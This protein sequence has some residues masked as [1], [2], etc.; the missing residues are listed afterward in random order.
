MK[1]H[2][3]EI[4]N[5]NSLKG[6]WKINLDD[7]FFARNHN[8]FVIH[9][10]TGSGKT[11]ILDAITLALYGCT[12]RLKS[13]SKTTNEA[14]SLNTGNCLAR[15]TYTSRGKRYVSQFSQ[16]RAHNN[17]GGNLLN[18][19]CYI[20]DLSTNTPTEKLSPTALKEKTE[21]LIGLSYD[22][23]CRSIL[24]AQ[25][26][27]DS[28]INASSGERAQILAKLTG[29][30]RF[31]EI[32][33]RI[34]EKRRETEKEFETAR[35][36][37][38]AFSGTI[39]DQE[40]IEELNK[41]TN[42]LQ[43]K[44]E[45]LSKS[46]QAVDKELSWFKEF[47]KAQ[48]DAS[49]A[50]AK[51][52]VVIAELEKSRQ[53]FLR[54][55]NAERAEK[56]SLSYQNLSH[57]RRELETTGTLLRQ[58]T[59]KVCQL[60]EQ[61]EQTKQA[62]RNAE[63][64]HT[65]LALRFED[66]SQIWKKVREIDLLLD[67]SRKKIS[68]SQ[69]RLD[70]AKAYR[71]TLEEKLTVTSNRHA[72]NTEKAQQLS[73][74]LEQHKPDKNLGELIAT[75]KERS[76]QISELEKK[77]AVTAKDVT[78]L[79][80]RQT[81]ISQRLEQTESQKAALTKTFAD[82]VSS[83][84]QSIS[85]LLRTSLQAGKP[86]PVCGATEH[87]L[88]NEPQEASPDTASKTAAQNIQT[89]TRQ[90]EE[91]D[92]VIAQD[93]SALASAEAQTTA[94]REQEASLRNEHKTLLDSTAELS[95]PYQTGRTLQETIS[96]LQ[97]MADAYSQNQKLLDLALSEAKTQETLL[98]ELESQQKSADTELAEYQ[99]ELDAETENNKTLG[100]RRTELFGNKIVDQ[101]EN[102]AKHEL[103][104]ALRNKNQLSQELVHLEKEFTAAQTA[105]QKLSSDIQKLTKDL[106]TFSRDFADA[107][108]QNQFTDENDFLSKRISPEQQE[109]LRTKRTSLEQEIVRTST[110]AK[111]AQQRLDECAAKKSS[112]KEEAELSEEKQ[113]LEFQR[114]QA[115]Q[116]IGA[117]T[118]TLKANTE[119]LQKSKAALEEFN[120]ASRQ[121]D[122]WNQM[123][124]Y[125]GGKDGSELEV[126]VQSMMF[127]TLLQRA[128]KYVYDI[129]GKYTLVQK[130]SDGVDFLIHDQ[131]F[132]S[133]GEN[134]PVS[135]L[136]GGEKF[137]ISLSLA[138]GIAELASQNVLVQ[139]LFLDE[140][141]GTLSGRPLTEAINAL[142]RLQT[143][144][145][146]LGIIT[147]VQEVINEFNGIEVS[148]KAGGY[149]QISGP[150]VTRGDTAPVL[151]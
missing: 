142:K 62:S 98:K 2:S 104:L 130:D 46:L 27:F 35:T 103:E 36:K 96:E 57:T 29:T 102:S 131:N 72:E 73:E 141:F 85:K 83:E 143:S 106:D 33:R 82:Y 126:F 136:S 97:K 111:L 44:L 45:F 91:L 47:R 9:G 66:N 58:E 119:A 41:E 137:V 128:N 15:I 7:E 40:K 17:P 95:A 70:S 48:N 151:Q 92:A 110:E 49:E 4:E 125:V 10:S 71:T 28:F 3:I 39:L 75:L 68:D 56:C 51:N 148:P 87:P 37:M 54:L 109:T 23:F 50:K 30:E 34:L 127:K 80:S 1:I 43:D 59:Q 65:D 135:N 147:H 144:G 123:K 146:T 74:Y 114:T 24:L 101:E 38:E 21:Q 61:L 145:K 77:I 88:C 120:K 84:Y 105:E 64:A 124:F 76:S 134:R 22:Q 78:S 5:L 150:G 115:E 25:G 129:S 132:D 13:V 117:N 26:E 90:L 31:K 42:E 11:T 139:S 93:K 133:P 121:L 79:E 89:I 55:E 20:W 113:S 52:Q 122:I 32:G 118:Q 69:K 16:R 67:S 53:D 12:P 112:T 108:E 94:I 63:K 100:I 99:Q 107:L 138:L 86:C 8:Q 6:Y 116:K 149:S 140:G 18:P 81:Q 14:M 60:K 19:E